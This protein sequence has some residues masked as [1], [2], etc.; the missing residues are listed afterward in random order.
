MRELDERDSF[1]VNIFFEYTVLLP[2]LKHC[3][4]EIET[5]HCHINAFRK[6]CNTFTEDSREKTKN[7]CCRYTLIFVVVKHGCSFQE[8]GILSS[9]MTL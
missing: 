7:N 1:G 5:A 8:V 2:F 9:Q 3:G 4:F 6:I